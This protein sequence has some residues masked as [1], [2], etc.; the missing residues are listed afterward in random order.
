MDKQKISTNTMVKTKTV[1]KTAMAIAIA[2]LGIAAIAAAGAGLRS[3]NNKTS[4]TSL[5]RAGYVCQDTDTTDQNFAGMP[6]QTYQYVNVYQK[7]KTKGIHPTTGQVVVGEDKCWDNGRVLEYYCDK[8]NN[9]LSWNSYNCEFGC[10]DGECEYFD[11]QGCFVTNLSCDD[12]DSCTEDWCSPSTQECKHNLYPSYVLD[13]TSGCS[14]SSTNGWLNFEATST[15]YNELIE[16]ENNFG[17]FSLS[18]IEEN[19]S[20]EKVQFRLAVNNANNPNLSFDSFIMRDNSGSVVAGPV[21]AVFSNKSE[22]FDVYNIIFYPA[23][24]IISNTNN[25]LTLYGSIS[26]LIVSN[27]FFVT[28][29]THIL[30]SNYIEGTLLSNGEKIVPESNGLFHLKTLYYN[31]YSQ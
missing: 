19:I 25:T 13:N 17:S 15:T 20:I 27:E 9:K 12:G 31:G 28:M 21:E 29:E 18:A 26:N 7:G 6:M 16:G 22:A 11:P 8:K 3:Q 30:P 10:N 2:F 1:S 5:S 24:L 14:S 4:A 23:G